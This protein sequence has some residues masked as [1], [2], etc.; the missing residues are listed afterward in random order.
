LINKIYYKSGYKYQL[1]QDYY[2]VLPYFFDKIKPFNAELLSFSPSILI[3]REH[4]AWDGAS[5]PAMD[6][7][8]IMRAS[9]VHDAL[10][11]LIRMGLIDEHYKKYA[12]EEFY[13]ICKEDG[14]SSFRAWY[15]FKA[16]SWFG[17]DSATAGKRKEVIEAP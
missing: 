13:K 17:K 14:V 16:V 10:Y 3:I 12:D 11:Q 4:Y 2:H 5:G 6:N 15:C 1:E 8:K 7:K 9:L